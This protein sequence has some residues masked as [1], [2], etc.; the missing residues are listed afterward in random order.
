MQILSSKRNIQKLHKNRFWEGLGPHLGRVWDGL[1]PLLGALGRLLDASWA[2]KSQQYHDTS[3]FFRFL[4]D[5]GG[6]FGGFGEV[7]GGI[8]EDFGS[9]Q[10][11]V[12]RSW[13]C[14]VSF[15]PAGVDSQLGPPRWSAK[16]H[17]A[18]GS[19]PQRGRPWTKMNSHELLMM[20]DELLIIV[21]RSGVREA[22]RGSPEKDFSYRFCQAQSRDP[23]FQ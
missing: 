3:D 13:K 21:T 6:D 16:R 9:S 19:S 7:W 14:L 12:G 17:N 11:R 15:G 20:F 18:R 10:R 22:A 5:L 23:H 4:V 1:G 8:W 2:L